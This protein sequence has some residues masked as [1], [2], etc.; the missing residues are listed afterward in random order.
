MKNQINLLSQL[1]ELILTVHHCFI[2]SF[3]HLK[4]LKVVLGDNGRQ[5]MTRG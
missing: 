4:L 2:L 3:Q 5:F 1:Q